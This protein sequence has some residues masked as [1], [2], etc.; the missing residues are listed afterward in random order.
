MYLKLLFL[1]CIT[2]ALSLFACNDNVAVNE[3]II[4]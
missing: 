1:I 4:G 3:K 2:M